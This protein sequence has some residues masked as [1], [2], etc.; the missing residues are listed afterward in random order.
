MI[1][2]RRHKVEG[3][4]ATRARKRRHFIMW[5]V[6]RQSKRLHRPNRHRPAS[7]I[8]T[9]SEKMIPARDARCADPSLVSPT[10]NKYEHSRRCSCLELSHQRHR[11]NEI[12][13]YVANSGSGNSTWDH[14]SASAFW[15]EGKSMGNRVDIRSQR[16][17][18]SEGKEVSKSLTLELR[19]FLVHKKK[20]RLI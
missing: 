1:T 13:D 3:H 9:G 12:E 2:P 20:H 17:G 14:F 5:S 11:R 18:K 8:W 7:S 4:Y 19:M 16:R 6:G 15:Q 10:T